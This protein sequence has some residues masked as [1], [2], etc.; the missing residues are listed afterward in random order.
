MGKI[1]LISFLIIAVL[2]S[3]CTYGPK[4]ETQPA[5]PN[6][7]E[8]KGFAFNPDTITIA[9]GTTVTWTNQ[10]SVQHTVTGIGNDIDSPI[11]SPGQTYSFTFNDTG[12]F[13]Y[14]C[15]IHPTMKGKVIVT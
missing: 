6:T 10:D 9:K 7:V 1:W 13:E 2:A 5:A 12:T 11:L 3:G 4:T 8:I 15:H 14:Q